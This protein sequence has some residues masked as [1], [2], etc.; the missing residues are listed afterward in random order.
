MT[1]I[2]ASFSALQLC[3]LRGAER[4]D[5]G[6]RDDKLKEEKQIMMKPLRGLDI[7]EMRKSG[8]GDNPL[9]YLTSP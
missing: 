1:R 6:W 4:L 5:R 3:V 8:A 9:S 7:I 2:T